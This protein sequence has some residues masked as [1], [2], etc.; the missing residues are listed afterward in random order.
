MSHRGE[1][2]YFLLR[3]EGICLSNQGSV[4]GEF[5]TG[6]E[7]VT[8]LQ[9]RRGYVFHIGEEWR[10][11]HTGLVLFHRGGKNYLV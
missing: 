8:F 1:E 3:E 6:E 10:L 7:R 9:G 5:H 4:S 11:V 2:D